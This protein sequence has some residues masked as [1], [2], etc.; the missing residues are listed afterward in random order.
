VKPGHVPALDGCQWDAASGQ[1]IVSIRAMPAGLWND[2]SGR[3]SQ[4]PV[5]GVGQKAYIGPSSVGGVEAGAVAPC[6]QCPALT[7]E[8]AFYLVRV[9]PPRPDDAVIGLLRDFITRTARR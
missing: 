7:V 2:L 1:G 9:D 8:N 3:T 5:Q 6:D 4:R